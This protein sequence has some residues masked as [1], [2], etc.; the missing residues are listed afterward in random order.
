M[1]SK[2]QIE[3][4]EKRHIRRELKT[5]RYGDSKLTKIILLKVETATGTEREL[6]GEKRGTQIERRG[7]REIS[8]TSGTSRYLFPAAGYSAALLPSESV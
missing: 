4:T 2:V 1:K 8:G 3:T 5:Y 7:E 6:R